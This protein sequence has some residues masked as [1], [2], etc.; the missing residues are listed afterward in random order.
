MAS[1]ND[2]YKILG[3]SRNASTQEIL[4]AYKKLALKYHPDRNLNNEKEAS[5]KFQQISEAASILRDPQKRKM[6]DTYGVA[7][8]EH[9]L[10]ANIDDL[11]DMVFS[12]DVKTDITD[13][14]IAEKTIL[15]KLKD[16][17]RGKQAEK[18]DF[19]YFYC[20]S[21]H[22]YGNDIKKCNTCD[23]NGYSNPIKQKKCGK[24]YHKGYKCTNCKDNNLKECSGIVTMAIPVGA[25]Q[26]DILTWPFEDYITDKKVHITGTVLVNV[27]CEMDNL[28]ELK[29]NDLYR[30]KP[31]KIWLHDALCGGKFLFKHFGK[32]LCIKPSFNLIQRNTW[33]KIQGKGMMATNN[34]GF[35]GDLFCKFEV[36]MPKSPSLNVSNIQQIC[37]ILPS[38]DV[39]HS[40][41]TYDDVKLVAATDDDM[42]NT[43]LL[44]M[45]KFKSYV[46]K[47][48]NTC[49]A[50]PNDLHEQGLK[51][52]NGQY[53]FK[54]A[55]NVT[56]NV[57][58]NCNIKIIL[59]R[60]CG[61]NLGSF[62]DSYYN[63]NIKSLQEPAV[64]SNDIIFKKKTI[65]L[66]LNECYIGVVQKKIKFEYV[67]QCNQKSAYCSACDGLGGKWKDE[68][69]KCENC[70][71]SSRKY[72][73]I[74][75][76][77]MCSGCIGSGERREFKLYKAV[78]TNFNKTHTMIKCKKCD[79][80]GIIRST[81]CNVCNGVRNITK[82][83]YKTCE[84]CDGS[85]LKNGSK[86]RCCN[87]CTNGKLEKIECIDIPAGTNDGDIVYVS[88]KGKPFLIEINCLKDDEYEV[89]GSDLYRIKPIIITLRDALL[90][91][92]FFIEH[93]KKSL[94]V[95][96]H[97]NI[98]LN[99][100]WYKIFE[101]G[102]C[103]P[104][105]TFVGDL[106]VKFQIAMPQTNQLE[107]C[108]IERI[109]AMLPTKKNQHHDKFAYVELQELDGY[110][111]L[112][113][114]DNIND[115]SANDM[116]QAPE[117][118]TM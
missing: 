110:D 10:P 3:I 34:S 49:I 38:D 86:R 39:K 91:H 24:C 23:G 93:F 116:Q 79:G 83:V 12:D 43:M 57:D 59:C 29:Q 104:N 32:T 46:C 108:D 68:L 117:C 76:S 102:M 13:N 94:L 107:E 111:K 106:F 55:F 95:K 31:V 64:I 73:T 66:S 98:I 45:D 4:K 65:D 36:D 67:C 53:I 54:N 21:C 48:C 69:I 113:I 63:L 22:L 97:S 58:E 103:T 25:R 101:R 51:T 27:K 99:D 92:N 28:Y 44:S 74:E 33:Y 7:K 8:T 40:D 41:G 85:S 87:R 115:D 56:V 75:T 14:I 90:G 77:Q 96:S 78:F 47:H 1:A 72:H 62:I 17:Y 35:F 6:Y 42:T 109:C 2:Y 105:A 9:L 16:C 89:K 100:K 118:K 84:S 71:N 61:S 88:V 80:E 81:V 112:G 50:L 11:F 5:L 15:V 37:D 52:G 20:A 82:R 30:T 19:K 26:N 114:D 70:N 60:K 18:I